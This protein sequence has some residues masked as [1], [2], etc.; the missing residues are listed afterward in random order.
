MNPWIATSDKLPREGDAVR[1]VVEQHGIHLS[2][3]YVS[4]VFKSRWSCHSP[5]DV[6]TWQRLDDC[7]DPLAPLHSEIET[8]SAL[9]A[10]V[11][12]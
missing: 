9:A 3:L 7:V 4:C 12:A 10:P 1:F 6:S 5:A 2:G 11:A 8:V